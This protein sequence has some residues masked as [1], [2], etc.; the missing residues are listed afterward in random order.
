MK[1][2]AYIRVSTDKQ[3]SENQRNEISRYATDKKLVIDEWHDFEVSSRKNDEQ[4]GITQLLEAL[5]KG[6][7]LIVS[8]LSRLGRSTIGVLSLI[9]K[10]NNQGITVILLR[11]NLTL[12]ND[13]NNSQSKMMITLFSMFAEMERDIISE[14]T[15]EAL[16]SRKGKGILGHKK[17][18]MKSK[19][20]LHEDAIY[21]FKETMNMSFEKICLLIDVKKEL[22]FKAQSLR[23]WFNKRYEKDLFTK[24]YQKTS[25]YSKHTIDNVKKAF[26]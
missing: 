2:I 6:D 3:T 1:T 16:K 14:R 5:S 24:T 23:T 11:Q 26:K 4:R 19:Y 10:L 25:K 20:D 22:G 8:E 12:S 18:F 13:K 15:K 21:N 7:T 9:D 17:D